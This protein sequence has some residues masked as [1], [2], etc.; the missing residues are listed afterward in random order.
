MTDLEL[1]LQVLLKIIYQDARSEKE[2]NKLGK[3]GRK[4]SYI[5]KNIYGVLE[6]K[7]YLDYMIGKLSSVKLKKIEK[8]VLTIL[9][10]GFYNIRFLE[11]ENFAVVNELVDL[12]KKYNRRSAGFVNAILRN[13]IRKYD[14]VIKIEEEDRA[15]TWGIK[16]SLP[17]EVI[18]YL[19]EDYGRDYVED[20]LTYLNTVQTLSIRVN[21][22]RIFK[23]NLK[24]LL[25]EEG[26]KPQDSKISDRALRIL[27]PTGLVESK[28]FKDGLFTI[29]SEASLKAAEVLDP[30]PGGRILDLCAAPGTK[31]T[32]LAEI[33][34]SCGEIVA[35][36]IS[37]GKNYLVEEN[38]RRLGLKNI[39]ITNFDATVPIEAFKGKFDFCLVDA[40]CSGLGVMGRKPEIRYKKSLA[41]IRE[42]AEIQGKTLDNAVDYLAPGGKLVFSTCT[43][44]RLEN[45]ENY[46]KLAEDE[47]L[48][49]IKIDGKDYLEFVNFKDLTDGFFISKFERR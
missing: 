7:A 26:F 16:S 21:T 10:L 36:D 8:K 12:T 5:S 20:F 14:R 37:S 30:Q 27:N 49:P 9:E 47:R 46:K 13:F 11:R 22:G 45:W 41:N 35:N 42:L 25:E 4:L 2:I 28:A 3:S 24:T 33:T 38:I 44:G 23:E 15:G 39:E 19:E 6:N 31:T 18:S 1:C 48:S 34:G 17:L 43:L 40:P 29:Q 32:A